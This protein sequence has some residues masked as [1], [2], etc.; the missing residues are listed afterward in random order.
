MKSSKASMVDEIIDA[1]ETAKEAYKLLPPALPNMK[2]VHFRVLNAIYRIRDNT[3]SSRISDINKALGFQLPTTT[4][5]INEMV[6]LNIVEKFAMPA[7]KRVVLVRT[8]EAGEK[9]L[10][11]CV[12]SFRERL[13]DEFSKINESDCIAMIET[14][15]KVH[16]SI[17][18]ATQD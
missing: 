13:Q 7:D 18:Q 5:F 1:L 14:I 2:P 4:K 11:E 15:H 6:E 17:K 16:Q 3:A 9:Y 12:T 8:T 10:H